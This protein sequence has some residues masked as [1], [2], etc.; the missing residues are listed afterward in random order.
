MA[1]AATI[2]ALALVAAMF[3]AFC[4]AVELLQQA[5]YHEVLQ[6]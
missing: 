1:A 5:S 4:G 3:V 6:N 2:R